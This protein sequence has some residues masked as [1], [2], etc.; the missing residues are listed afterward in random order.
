VW[1]EIDLAT[2]DHDATT[3]GLLLY[4]PFPVDSYLRN[5]VGAL[6]ATF[7][8]L[9]TGGPTTDIDIGIGGSDA[10]LDLTLIN[11]ATAGQDIAAFASALLASSDPWIAL[12]GLYIVADVITAS[13]T[14]ATGTIELGFEFTYLTKAT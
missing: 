4:G 1:A 6:V 13:T 14:P 8:D 2:T 9:D 5:A 11:G 7:T 10:V 3:D 12:G